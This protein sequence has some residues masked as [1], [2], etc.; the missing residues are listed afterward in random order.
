M[1]R[2]VILPPF[3]PAAPF[4][5][6]SGRP[7]YDFSRR[8]APEIISP[9]L[10]QCRLPK[11]DEVFQV[12]AGDEW[13]SPPLHLASSRRQFV[14]LHPTSVVQGRVMVLRVAVTPLGAIILWPTLTENAAGYRSQQAVLRAAEQGWV[15]LWRVGGEYRHAKVRL[16]H[17]PMYPA[18]PLDV[19]AEQARLR[20]RGKEAPHAGP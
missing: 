8:L 18:D 3:D 4:P 6:A 14:L 15:R 11:K 10:A 16:D 13:V 9:A 19:L 20:P 12:L 17:P 1:S 5:S 2:P 7:A